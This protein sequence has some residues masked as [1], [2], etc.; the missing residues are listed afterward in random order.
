[1]LSVVYRFRVRFK[2]R[3]FV[4]KNFFF[5]SAARTA[6]VRETDHPRR[7]IPPG[8]DDPVVKPRTEPVARTFPRRRADPSCDHGQTQHGH[9]RHRVRMGIRQGERRPDG[10]AEDHH[11]HL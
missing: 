1:M 5:V 8:D 6:A 7:R 11:G 3:L 2:R 9:E 10:M 4:H